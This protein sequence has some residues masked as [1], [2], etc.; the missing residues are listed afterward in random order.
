LVVLEISQIYITEISLGCV[1]EVLEIQ[2]V[3]HLHGSF[4]DAVSDF[5]R[6]LQDM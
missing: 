4:D 6:Q 1:R 5:E 3:L 2:Y